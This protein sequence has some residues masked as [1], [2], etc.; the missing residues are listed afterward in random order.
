MLPR[1]VDVALVSRF[2]WPSIGGVETLLNTLGASLIADGVRVRLFAHRIDDRGTDWLGLTDRGEAFAPQHNPATGMTTTQLRMGRIQSN[3]LRASY[4]LG[5]PE[6]FE[7]LHARRA[8]RVFASQL[9]GATIV[10]RFSGGRMAVATMLA[11]R[12]M[13][14]PAV[15]TPVAHP[16]QWDDDPISARAYREA[17]L[18]IATTA[19]DAEVYRRL[20]VP[21]DRIRVCPLPTPPPGPGDGQALRRQQRIEGPLVLFIGVRRTYKGV[22]ELV[23]A[24][25]RLT[26]PEA[27]VA[28]VGPGPPLPHVPPNVLDVGAV[29]D[30]ERS[31]WLGAADVVCLPSAQ[32]SFGLAVSEAWSV[33]TPVVTS[34]IPVLR[35][36]TARS[37]GGIATSTEP[38]A[39]ADALETLLGDEALRRR[40]GAAGHAWWK[41]HESPESVAAWHR[42]TYADLG[43]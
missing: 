4:R 42:A 22:G 37:G 9:A 34:D 24:A 14:T 15:V 17:D 43:G 18:V 3:L 27:R 29:S 20:G 19:S 12:R 32:E 31:A 38:A 30:V 40:M 16:G 23:K 35:E 39:L 10:H 36:R 6:R 28:F 7:Q 2:A 13:G 11:A 26:I 41:E 21:D 8:A 5:G 33:Q 1:I 25:E